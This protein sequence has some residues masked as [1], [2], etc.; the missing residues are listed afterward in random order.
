MSA[1]EY[2]SPARNWLALREGG[3]RGGKGEREG[4][5]ERE[6]EEEEGGGELAREVEEGRR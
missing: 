2:S 3:R 6:R 1:M 5:R 4:E